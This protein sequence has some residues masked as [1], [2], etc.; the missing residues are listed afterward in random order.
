MGSWWSRCKH[1]LWIRAS[2]QTPHK[3]NDDFILTIAYILTH[4]QHNERPSECVAK[5]CKCPNGRNYQVDTE[6]HE[7]SFV[8]CEYC[9][10]LAV[11]LDCLDD[12]EF[13]CDDCNKVVIRTQAQA[14]ASS[15]ANGQSADATTAVV[16]SSS[17][18][19]M[20]TDSE[21]NM[22]ANDKMIAAKFNMPDCYVP[23]ISLKADD[24]KS[25]SKINYHKFLTLSKNRPITGTEDITHDK[26]SDEN[27]IQPMLRKSGKIDAYFVRVPDSDSDIEIAPV[28]VHRTPKK[29]VFSASDSQP[30]STATANLNDMKHLN[31]QPSN[32][33]SNTLGERKCAGGED[34]TARPSV[35]ICNFFRNASAD[36]MLA[37]KEN[38][39]PTKSV[40]VVRPFSVPESSSGACINIKAENYPCDAFYSSNGGTYDESPNKS[41]ITQRYDYLKNIPKKDERTSIDSIATHP[42]SPIVHASSTGAIKH[43]PN[44]RKY[45]SVRSYL[46]GTSSSDE[47]V[48]EPKPKR[49][50]PKRMK[51][52]LSAQERPA[53]QSTIVNFF[54]PK[55]NQGIQ[56]WFYKKRFQLKFVLLPVMFTHFAHKL[57]STVEF[58][59]RKSI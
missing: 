17:G 59:G 57:E 45:P 44:K 7:H 20:V 19:F 42:T 36:D 38:E 43:T 58:E 3:Q 5:V 33:T 48:T 9:G 51:K 24:F 28:N 6:N 14:A 10:S 52:K 54:Q 50:S 47:E 40:A 12:D 15:S 13:R 49:K 21:A 37:G 53:N 22:R 26:P 55:L 39:K 2:K 29:S 25:T 27:E 11:H 18:A 32:L 46:C 41:A 8:F 4:F 16:G 23:L 30:T 1:I 34:E 56:N 35:I 31:T